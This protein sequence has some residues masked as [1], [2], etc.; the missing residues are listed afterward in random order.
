MTKKRPTY[1]RRRTCGEHVWPRS[2][3]AFRCF[4]VHKARASRDFGKTWVTVD[5]KPVTTPVTD[6][7]NPA[8]VRDYE[9]EERLVYL[10]DL[11]F[12]AEGRPILLYLTSKGY[13]AGP[14]NDPRIWYTARWTGRDWQIRTFTTSDHNYDMG[15]L[16]IEAD[17]TWRIFAPTEPGPQPYGAGGEIALWSSTDQGQSWKKEKVLTKNSPRNHTY[18]RR[19]LHAHPDFYALW[20]DGDTRQASESHLYFTNQTSDRVWKLPVRMS[21]GDAQPEVVDHHPAP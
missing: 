20:A 7:K 12:D 5:G 15:S 4:C 9:S 1:R 18:V 11:Q 21:A 19:P 14:A 17:G 10:K 13:A 2:C 6:V 16:Y 3:A 8:L